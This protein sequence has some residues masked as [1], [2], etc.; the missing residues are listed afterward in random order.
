MKKKS[1][2]RN[3]KLNAVS[4]F[5][6]ILV[7]ILILTAFYFLIVKPKIILNQSPCTPNYDVNGDNIL[8]GS[9]LSFVSSCVGSTSQNCQISDL[10]CDSSINAIDTQIMVN[11]LRSSMN[12]LPQDFTP[13]LSY[14]QGPYGITLINS[15]G[16]IY[17]SADGIN[18]NFVDRSII[19]AQ[20]VP[21]AFTP[22]L[23]YYS[24]LSEGRGIITL[25]NSSGAIY[26]TN[27]NNWNQ[28]QEFSLQDKQ[29]SGLPMNYTPVTARFSLIEQPNTVLWNS[30]GFMYMK[31]GNAP[32]SL[33]LN[34][35]I[36][37]NFPQVPQNI[38]PIFSYYAKFGAEDHNYFWYNVNGQ[39]KIYQYTRPPVNNIT[40]ISVSGLPSGI[41][42]AGYY[43]YIDSANKRVIVWY[44]NKA[45]QSSDGTTFL[46]VS[47][48]Y[49]NTCIPDSEYTCGD[50]G[51]CSQRIQT[52]TCSNGC[53]EKQESQQCNCVD[54]DADI[55]GLVYNLGI[56][57][58]YYQFGNVSY[59][60]GTTNVIVND[61]CKDSQNLTEM[62]CSN[63]FL[64]NVNYTCPEGCDEE[65]GVCSGVPEI[66]CKDSDSGKDYNKKGSVRFYFN[67]NLIEYMNDTCA[68]TKKLKEWYCNDDELPTSI[69][70]NCSN[71]CSNGACINEIISSSQDECQ[72]NEEFCTPAGE[73]QICVN[74]QWSDPVSPPSGKCNNIITPTGCE[75]NSD[76]N[77]DET[78][79]DGICEKTDNSLSAGWIILII[80][81]IIVI[82]AVIGTIIYLVYQRNKSGK[83]P[84]SGPSPGSS[85]P[86]SPPSS[87]LNN[88]ALNQ[89][90]LFAQRSFE[91][92]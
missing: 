55:S 44:G 5:I 89:K 70:F 84:K 63:G 9:D 43:N 34:N 24:N 87:S 49:N 74:G 72:N 45:Y 90:P 13:I 26:Y 57:L 64:S 75:T 29:T 28:W 11:Y 39:L 88:P 51:A 21:A 25:F 61:T 68:T 36:K 42:T 81:L 41:P 10:N 2:K 73:Y 62:I 48:R 23:G 4:I 56:Y 47:L 85:P 79:N 65:E 66:S 77:P 53:V 91:K 82:L 12:N 20:G 38:P 50:W 92:Q 83:K 33:S 3:N 8:N 1:V 59:T 40:P 80:I 27:P 54:S 60:V 7:F 78:C 17:A 37:T 52:R 22:S 31:V 15:D 14:S 35:I 86:K 30:S 69:Y 76:C 19:T 71:S 16:L 46:E 6:L 18:F 58:S 67:G 32:W